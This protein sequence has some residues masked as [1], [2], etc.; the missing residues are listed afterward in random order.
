MQACQVEHGCRSSFCRISVAVLLLMLICSAVGAAVDMAQPG[1]W[2]LFDFSLGQGMGTHW[3]DT[4]GVYFEVSIAVEE[5]PFQRLW[6]AEYD[7]VD[8]WFPYT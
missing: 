3:Q 2:L 6:R 8:R 7:K 4:G 5:G 1:P